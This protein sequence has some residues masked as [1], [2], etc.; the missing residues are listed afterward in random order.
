M[1]WIALIGVA[2]ML[3]LAADQHVLRVPSV[4]RARILHQ[5]LPAYPPDALDHHLAG[6]VKMTVLIGTDGRVEKVTLIS[7]H[8][9]L[10]PAA[11][12]AAR[13]WVFKPFENREGV[14]ARAVTE[15][16]IPFT[17]PN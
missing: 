15:I 14:A 11:M 8:P 1:K 3:A 7:G 6:V 2:A 5:E 10:A 12:H 4:P 13:R 16:D 17:P 9:L